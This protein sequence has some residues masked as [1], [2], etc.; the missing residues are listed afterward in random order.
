MP[1]PLVR[2]VRRD[3]WTFAFELRSLP[4]VDLAGLGARSDEFEQRIQRA[5]SDLA[6]ATAAAYIGFHPDLRGLDAPDGWAVDAAAAGPRWDLLHRTWLSLGRA[7]SAAWLADWAGPDGVR[8]GLWTEGGTTCLPFLLAARGEGEGARVAV[9]AVDGDD[10][11]TFVFATDDVD[12]L[13][14]SLILTAFRREALSLPTDEL[15]RWAVAVRT[16]ATVQAARG[17]LVARVT[18]DDG[19]A[20]RMQAALRIEP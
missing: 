1:L 16:Q 20:Q 13:N 10:R 14:A 9:E 17:Q 4:G 7:E 5:R 15:G 18:H 8:L 6:E 3:G 12:R 19:W 2:A 11:A